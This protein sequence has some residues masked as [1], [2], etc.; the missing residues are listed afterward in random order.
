MY[1]SAAADTNLESSG[2]EFT[3]KY[4]ISA[5]SRTGRA[6]I[7][8]MTRHPNSWRIKIVSG[9]KKTGTSLEEP[10]KMP[11]AVPRS[12]IENQLFIVATQ[13]TMMPASAIPSKDL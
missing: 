8:N 11:I 4:Q 12:R 2:F 9:G 13:H 3:K 1:S 6:I 5:A 7:W 10:V